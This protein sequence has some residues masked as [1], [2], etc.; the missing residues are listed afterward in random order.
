[1]ND[2][3][4][5]YVGLF[6]ESRLREVDITDGKAIRG[7]EEHIKD[8]TMRIES[9][10]L[11]RDRQ[12]RGSAARANYSSIV[13]RLRDELAS[14]KRYA[15]REKSKHVT[16]PESR[17]MS[18]VAVKIGEDDFDVPEDKIELL[19]KYITSALSDRKT[20]SNNYSTWRPRGSLRK[21]KKEVSKY[22][23]NLKDYPEVLD[24]IEN[25]LKNYYPQSPGIQGIVSRHLSRMEPEEISDALKKRVAPGGSS[26][27]VPESLYSLAEIKSEKTAGSSF[28]RGELTIPLVFI[29]GK[30]GGSNALFD[31]EISGEFWHVKE[32]TPTVGRKMGSAREVAFSATEIYK[33]IIKTGVVE[34]STLGE[35]GMEKFAEMLPVILKGLQ[36]SQNSAIGSVDELYDII[37]NEVV[38]KSVGDAKGILWYNKGVYSFTEKEDLGVKGFTQQGRAILAVGAKSQVFGIQAKNAAAAERS[39]QKQARKAEKETKNQADIQ[40]LP[41]KKIRK[42]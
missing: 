6:L 2:T 18:E 13:S 23:D 38:E 35:M 37:R 33:K 12:S 21:S 40:P 14:A 34:P 10:V 27:P 24:E 42:K 39:A 16:L 4:K 31:A 11:W 28:G 15:E 3:L 22:K 20:R 36:E 8:L 30:L 9:A 1:M 7:S 25:L 5:E 26:V 29:D 17:S 41:S 32:G 19:K